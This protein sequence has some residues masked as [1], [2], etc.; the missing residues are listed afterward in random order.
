MNVTDGSLYFGHSYSERVALTLARS[1]RK[2]SKSGRRSR[3][4]S[5]LGYIF[6]AFRQAK[7]T[8]RSDALIAHAWRQM[9][10]GGTSPGADLLHLRVQELQRTGAVHVLLSNNVH[11]CVNSGRNLLAIGRGKRRLYTP[12]AHTVRVLYDQC[13]HITVPEQLYEPF[14]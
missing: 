6:S 3:I 10:I 5:C 7:V 4:A 1:S 13:R 8:S 12:V 11:P 2:L 9:S 14:V